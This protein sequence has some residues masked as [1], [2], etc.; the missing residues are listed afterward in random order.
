MHPWST[1]PSSASSL[2]P[3]KPVISTK[4]VFIV[5]LPREN[6]RD[7]VYK[8]S[9]Q[10]AEVSINVPF[11]HFKRKNTDYLLYIGVYAFTLHVT[12]QWLYEK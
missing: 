2:Y 12:L 9:W 4:R 1:T 8:R 10:H 6:F 3:P 11:A 5:C 7:S